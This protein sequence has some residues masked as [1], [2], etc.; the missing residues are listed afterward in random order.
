LASCCCLR[1]DLAK[2]LGPP[3]AEGIG[4]GEGWNDIRA[5]Q[6]ALWDSHTLRWLDWILMIFFGIADVL[7]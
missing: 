5:H 6:N 3:E 4:V 7:R 2:T 1:W